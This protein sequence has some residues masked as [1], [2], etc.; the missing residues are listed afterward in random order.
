MWSIKN[1]LIRL[2]L[3]VGLAA[4]SGCFTVSESEFPNVCAVKATTPDKVVSLSGFEAS[5]TTYTPIVSS[6]L[7]YA[8]HP[9]YYGRHWHRGGFVSADV[10]STT[11]YVPETHQTT[12]YVERA[13]GI[14]EDAGYLVGG[15]NATYRIQVDFAGPFVTDSDRAWR[16]VWCLASILTAD[17]ATETWHAKL[18][19][20]ESSTGRLVMS[21]TYEQPYAVT[22]WGPLPIFSPFSA[23]ATTDLA[24]QTWCLSALTDRAMADATAFL[25]QN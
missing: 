14:L 16:V 11:T 18:R 9:R 13:Q 4:L 21:N 10:V 20:Y 6:G 15:S 2:S 23:S 22:V 19:I 7:V 17:H 5:V 8:H 12:E 1:H 24:M 25:S 3:A